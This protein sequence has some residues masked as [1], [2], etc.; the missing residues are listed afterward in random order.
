[1]SAIPSDIRERI[2]AAA[3]TIYEDNRHEVFPTVDQVRRA[4]RAD[5]NTTSAV[6]RE[7]RRQQLAK[8]A[9]TAIQVPEAVS[10]AN[11]LALANLW[12]QA[13]ELANE[14][15]RAAQSAW[16]GERDELDSLRREIS[17][18]FEQQAKE[19]TQLRDEL[20]STKK[21][22]QLALEL[23]GRDLQVVTS[24]RDKLRM[25]LAALQ[26]KYE[27]LEQS[28]QDQKK[29]AATEVHRI[30]ERLTKIEAERDEE[31]KGASKA[32]EETARLSGQLAAHQEQMAVIVARLGPSAV[33]AKGAKSPGSEGSDDVNES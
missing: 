8:A 22:H 19:L 33:S 12:Q 21:A 30:A 7:W 4:A 3:T 15:L 28:Q 5:M 20:E 2:I 23:Q 25:E 32:R 31:R 27:A 13:Q 16:D 18:A 14:G 1:M 17:E 10:R 29:Q 11:S 24:E 26:V 9:P 6:M